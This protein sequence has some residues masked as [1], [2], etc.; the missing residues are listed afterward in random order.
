MH[1]QKFINTYIFLGVIFSILL[2]KFFW[3]WI[4][5]DYV[6][7]SEIPS[8]YSKFKYNPINESV[9]YV[10]FISLPLIVYLICIKIF[11]KQKIKKIKEI[12][13]YDKTK[14]FYTSDNKLLTLYFFIFLMLILLNFLS[15]KLPSHSIDMF[16]EGQWL[17]SATNYLQKGGYWTNTYMTRGLF[18]EILNPL[19]GLQIFDILSV[20]SS[21][22]SLLLWILVFKISLIIFIYKLTAIQKMNEN[23]K[24]LFFVLVSLIALC[25]TSY[26]GDGILTYRELPLIIFLILLIPIISNGK[27]VSFYCF[28][29]GVMSVIS[30]LW[31]ID[32]GAYL[33]LALAFLILF[34]IIK[35]DFRKSIWIITGITIGWILFYKIIG[36]EEFKSFLYNTKSVYQ[37]SDWAWGMIHPEPFSSER[38]SSRATKVLLILIFSGLLIINLNFFKYKNISNESKILLIFIFILSVI[39]YKSALVRSD[40]AHIK[41]VT[42]LP[43]LLLCII[44]INIIFDFILKNE[45]YLKIFQNIKNF[46]NTVIFVLISSSIFILLISNISFKNITNFKSRVQYYV[47]LNDEFFMSKNQNLLIKRYNNLTAAD[48]CILIFTYEAAIPYLLKKP[49]CN[50]FYLIRTIGDKK[51]Q[52]LFIKSIENQKPSFILLGGEY[53]NPIDIGPEPHELLPIINNFIME[54]YYLDESVLNWD[55]YKLKSS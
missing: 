47:N 32:R 37:T 7:E 52:N 24:I 4:E 9:R 26:F 45:K 10:A 20:G 50:K 40:G 14:N 1:S 6:K 22:F 8:E 11:K 51:N 55:I 48:K 53:N 42:G 38:H 21:R 28:L 29:I 34:L 25:M 49:S 30:M 17:T 27:I 31:G 15:I 13:F 2:S 3:G 44:I 35:K 12:F 43:M 54:N 39:S 16:H 41:T 46:K 5:I 33:N 19:I 23:L 18:G 36:S